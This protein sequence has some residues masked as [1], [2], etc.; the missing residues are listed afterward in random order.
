MDIELNRAT[1]EQVS[2]TIEEKMAFVFAPFASKPKMAL[3]IRI[4]EDTVAFIVDDVW[5]MVLSFEMPLLLK[6]I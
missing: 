5:C 6:K 4:F 1:E 2:Q 3:Y